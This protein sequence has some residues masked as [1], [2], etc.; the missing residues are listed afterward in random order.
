[1]NYHRRSPHNFLGLDSQPENP[2]LK[3][4]IFPVPYD[5]TTSYKGGAR[6]GPWAIIEA[7]RQVELYDIELNIDATETVAIET[8][9]ELAPSS[10]GPRE[11]IE[12]IEKIGK[13]IIKQGSFPLMLGGDHPI[14]IG[15][16][17]PLKRKYKQ[18][19]V[20]QIDAHT[21]LRNTYEGSK[22]S[23][24]CPMRRIWEAGCDVVSVGIRSGTKEDL[25]FVKKKNAVMYFGDRF[26]VKGVLKGLGENVYI[27]IDLDGFDP[28]VVPAVGTP[29]P[30]G[31]SWEQVTGLLKEVIKAKNVVGADVVELAPIP[32]Q[33]ASDFLAA[34][35]VYKIISFMTVLRGQEVTVRSG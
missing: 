13:D 6:E 16:A 8:L 30:G 5:A 3:V 24:A 7:S 27:T 17:R 2:K 14:A 29:E 12:Q 4:V 19:S 20:L 22:Y 23:H 1:M 10:D 26:D 35:L 18:L 15:M 32:G 28:S 31:L 25:E 33:H 34:R 11:V 9:P 21:D